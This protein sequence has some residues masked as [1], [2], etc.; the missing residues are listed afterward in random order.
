MQLLINRVAYLKNIMEKEQSGYRIYA[1]ISLPHLFDSQ[2]VV[3]PD[4][5]W[6]GGYFERDYEGQ[7]WI[8]IGNQR[9]VFDEWE[10]TLPSNMEV[11]GFKEIIVDDEDI[12]ESE[13]WFIGELS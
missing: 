5:S 7:K 13:I 11:R 3:I 10:L 6:F 1:L 12:Y 2:L 8:P 4:Q 9:N